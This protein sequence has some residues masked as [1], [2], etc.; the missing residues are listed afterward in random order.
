[1]DGLTIALVSIIG[2]LISLFVAKWIFNIP[3]ITK[4]SAKAAKEA[5]A[6]RRIVSKIAM[7]QGVDSNDIAAI[8]KD[9]YK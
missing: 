6:T 2:F 7:V 8:V 5:E 4:A 3:E 1:M 9:A